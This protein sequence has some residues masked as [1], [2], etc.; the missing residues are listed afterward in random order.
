MKESARVVRFLIIGTMNALIMAF[1]VWLMMRVL[2]I[3]YLVAN[4]T[5]YVVAQT[6]NFLWC[7]YWVFAI[8]NKKNSLWQQMLFFCFAFGLAYLAQFLFLVLLVELLGTN[9]YLAQFLGLFVYGGTNFLLNRRVT[10][11]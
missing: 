3:N 9:A 8:E 6:H 5:A 7:K 10:F 2:G 1:V 11:R 4:V